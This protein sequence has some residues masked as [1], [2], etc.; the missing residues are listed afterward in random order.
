MTKFYNKLDELYFHKDFGFLKVINSEKQEHLLNK[1]KSEFKN[2]TKIP[3]HLELQVL[4]EKLTNIEN[5]KRAKFDN[6]KMTYYQISLIFEILFYFIKHS[7]DDRYLSYFNESYEN[8]I[9]TFKVSSKKTKTNNFEPS[10][11]DFL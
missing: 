1:V 10:V 4:E 6:N 7:Q 11:D 3:E 5:S 2:K 9:L 8:Y